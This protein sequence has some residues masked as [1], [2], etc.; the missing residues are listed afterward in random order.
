MSTKSNQDN[1]SIEF[2]Q[3]I[4]DKINQVDTIMKNKYF[5]RTLVDFLLVLSYLE[6]D[7]IIQMDYSRY[8]YVY[9][10]LI[11]NKLNCI[12]NKHA[13][14][15]SM[16]KTI[17]EQISFTIYKSLNQGC[18][19]YNNLVEIIQDYRNHYPSSNTRIDTIINNLVDNNLLEEVNNNNFKFKFNYMY[20]YFISRHINGLSDMEKRK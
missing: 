6:Q 19:N 7:S 14:V 20:Y 1:T 13:T 12:S 17:L 15:A 18:V 16:Y 5:N 4:R 8:S 3:K 2:N 10:A 9:D 11:L